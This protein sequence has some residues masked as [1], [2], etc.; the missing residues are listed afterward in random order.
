M[1]IFDLEKKDYMKIEGNVTSYE[2]TKVMHS[3]ESL[4]SESP[5]TKGNFLMR[6]FSA[7]RYYN[8]RMEYTQWAKVRA[9]SSIMS[10]KNRTFSAGCTIGP[11]FFMHGGFG[12]IDGFN[13]GVLDDWHMFDIGLGI[14]CQVNVVHESRFEYRIRR[15]MHS[16]TAVVNHAAGC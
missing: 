3:F 2:E 7:S 11:G 4:K 16:M 13:D 5:N 9:N 15:R 6:L 8:A 1:V 14:W 12:L 10:P